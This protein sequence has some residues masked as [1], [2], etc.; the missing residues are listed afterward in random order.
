MRILRALGNSIQERGTGS[1]QG[2][3]YQSLLY[4]AWKIRLLF[5]VPQ[6]SHI[7]PPGLWSQ[8]GFTHQWHFSVSFPGKAGQAEVRVWS[9]PVAARVCLQARCYATNALWASFCGRAE[10]LIHLELAILNIKLEM[11]FKKPLSQQ[12]FPPSHFKRSLCSSAER[13]SCGQSNSLCSALLA[14]AFSSPCWASPGSLG[15]GIPGSSWMN[16]WSPVHEDPDCRC[17]T[18]FSSQLR[19]LALVYPHRDLI[20][21]SFSKMRPGSY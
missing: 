11:G 10:V 6:E 3:R 1:L 7:N 19:G 5:A 9:T 20:Y 18:C 21:T 4:L 14:P 12:S 16:S 2:A 17:G 8:Q 13:V 15:G